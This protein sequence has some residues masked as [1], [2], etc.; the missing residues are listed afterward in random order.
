M[1]PGD[2]YADLDERMTLT[3]DSGRA[4]LVFS[5]SQSLRDSTP[6]AYAAWLP[7]PERVE[8][9]AELAMTAMA[10]WLFSTADPRLAVALV[11]AGASERRHSHTMTNTLDSLP[12]A[13][14]AHRRTAE[15]ATGL[16]VEPL[17]VAQVLRHAL[18]LGA[19]SFRASPPGHPDAFDG[20]EAGAV[21][22][23]RAVARGEVI[24]PLSPV[25]QVALLA[26]TIVG[27]CL[28]VTRPG[29]PPYGGPW[30]VNVFRDPDSA[31]R[32]VGQALVES[33]LDSARAARLPGMSLA[34]SHRNER[35]RDLY[36]R[37]G[38]VEVGDSWRLALPT[39]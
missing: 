36:R 8:D 25:S 32:G 4:L 27:A 15:R 14:R 39:R 3:D 28:V 38:F 24:G 9:T 12:S 6:W 19:L 35:A 30:I 23:V 22:E 37:T 7:H 18:R 34:V 29:T 16:S 13:R 11:R 2:P 1:Q 31:A 17:T 20:D 33:S 21:A 10:G 26:G 5:A